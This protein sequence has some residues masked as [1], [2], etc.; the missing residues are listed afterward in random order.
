MLLKDTSFT[1]F[2][3]ET[4]GLYPYSGDRICEIG[5]IR[6]E[7]NSR[8]KKKFHSMV[9]PERPI[10]K[11]AFFVNRITPYM[12]N[13]A[14]KIHEILPR[15]MKFISNSVLV[16]YNAGFDV[17]FLECALGEKKGELDKYHV[18]DALSLARKLFSGLGR[19]NLAHVALSLGVRV[20]REHRA[21]FDADMTLS[22]FQE[23]LRVL[24][25]EG[26]ESVED[27]AILKPASD[28]SARKV[29]DFKL[30]LIRRAIREEKKLNITYLSAWGNQT[31]TRVITPKE[32][33]KGY[34]KSYLVAFCHLRNE[35]RNFRLDGIVKI[36][37]E[38]E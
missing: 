11:G 37:S 25:D 28:T 23:E 17:G 21:I 38:D 31:T 29:K 26:V 5:A 19:Y 15:F 2:D 3:F 12:L 1:I 4:T 35:E 14:P 30:E 24:I 16:A 6:I 8:T 22:I 18:I 36:K 32:I 34:D 13:G 9:D 27:I 20:S 33:Q 7:P 10:S